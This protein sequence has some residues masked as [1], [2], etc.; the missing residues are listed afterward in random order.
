MPLSRQ[1]SGS[2]TLASVASSSCSSGGAPLTRCAVT[3]AFLPLSGPRRPQVLELTQAGRLVFS[4]SVRPRQHVTFVSQRRP[5][6][7]FALT[8]RLG[9]LPAARLSVCCERRRPAGARLGGAASPLVMLEVSGGAGPCARCLAASDRRAQ[10]HRKHVQKLDRRL[11]RIFQATRLKVAAAAAASAEPVRAEPPAEAGSD[12]T[13][14]S[15]VSAASEASADAAE[16]SPPASP[17]PADS[18]S[19]SDSQSSDSESEAVEEASS[20]VEESIPTESESE[21]E[22]ESVR[23]VLPA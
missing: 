2:G 16:R 14:N 18:D 23:E 8:A 17:P 20:D 21:S 22:S 11:R 13:E 6:E 15:A 9:Q 1:S 3:V 10:R 7:P 12:V 19:D 4:G 5:P